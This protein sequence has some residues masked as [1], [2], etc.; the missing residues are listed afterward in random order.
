LKF[1]KGDSGGPVLKKINNQW[2]LMGIVSNGDINCAGTGI[3]TNVPF[4]YNWIM[5]N[6]KK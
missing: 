3:Y 6:L 2:T 4:Y 1:L 5:K